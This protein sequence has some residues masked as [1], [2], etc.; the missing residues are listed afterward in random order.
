MTTLFG[1]TAIRLAILVFAT[2][3][4]VVG[5]FI[6]YLAYRGLRRNDS[7][8]MLYLS[9]G[10]ILLFGV[11]YGVSILGTVLLQ[12]RVLSLPYQDP[13]RLVVRMIQFTGL[14]CLAYSLYLGRSIPD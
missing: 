7:K 10:M 13:F 5:L 4:A 3:S 6:G 1:Y 9:V 14:L 8:Q 11:A 12:L 2:G